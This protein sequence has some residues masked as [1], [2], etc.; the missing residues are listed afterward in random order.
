MDA[1]I[2]KPARLAIVEENIPAALK[3]L[4]R[5]VCWSWEWRDTK[6]DKPP[7]DVSGRLAKSNDPKTWC[8]FAQAMAAYQGGRFDGVGIVLGKLDDGRSLAGVDLDRVRDPQSGA[9]APWAVWVVCRLDTY[10]EVSPS[11]KGVKFFC[12]GTLPKGKR[13]DSDGRGVEMYDGGRYFTITGAKLEGSPGEVKDRTAD[14]HQLHPTLLG[15]LPREAQKDARQLAL[16]KL[17]HVSPSLANGY[18]DWLGVGMALHSIDDGLLGAWDEWSRSSEKYKDGECA[19]KW[20]TFTRGGAITGGSLDFW[21]RQNGWTGKRESGSLPSAASAPSSNGKAKT[22]PLTETARNVAAAERAPIDPLSWLRCYGVDVQKVVKIGTKCGVYDLLLKDGPTIQLGGVADVLSPK[23]VQQRVADS[24][25]TVIPELKRIDWRPIGA[26]IIR[27]ASHEDVDADPQSELREWIEGFAK[28][29]AN[30]A[31]KDDLEIINALEMF[32][33]ARLEDD[34]IHIGLMKFMAAIAS[35]GQMKITR[36]DIIQR[37]YRDGFKRSHIHRR[38][39]DRDRQ[40][41][42][43]K[44]Q[45]EYMKNAQAV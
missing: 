44:S 45:P 9:L 31:A 18:G 29:H 7:R 2:E 42:S 41:K 11:Q 3:E 17:R 36:A 13:S 34:T 28:Q 37:L 5:W 32:G 33:I 4:D 15:E 43:W 22:P 12:W 38:D 35:L 39:K 24:I 20:A 8:N 16:E 26:E 1:A 14:L 6:W 10:C 23:I 30:K 21:A 25:R 27:I 19:K 40:V